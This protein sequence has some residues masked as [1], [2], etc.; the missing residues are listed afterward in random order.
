MRPRVVR[1]PPGGAG[2]SIAHALAL[3]LAAVLLSGCAGTPQTWA[4]TQSPPALPERFELRQVP[5]FPQQA[6]QC[7]P[8][9]LATLLVHEGVE[10]SPEALTPRLFIPA[11]EGT[12]QLELLAAA[13]GHDRLAV[14]LEPELGAVL[15]AVA[16]GHPVL[17]LQNLGLPIAP[18]WHYAVVVGYDLA[19]GELVLR[20]GAERRWITPLGTF[21]RTWA[22]GEHWA[23]VTVAPGEVPAG[24]TLLD[25]LAAARDLEAGGKQA[26]ARAS[27]AAAAR[28][29]PGR[30]LPELALANLDYAQGDL[31]AAE[32]ALRRAVRAEPESV[33][34]WNN[35]AH[36]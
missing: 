5:F 32:A 22:R 28:A 12:L 21:E 30:A 9:A 10:T 29:W 2:S 26:A 14:A 15:D 20:S 8:A 17:V 35:L 34:A 1:R 24:V 7:G 19:A 13:R 16:A 31:E 18:R 27:Y 3:A 25:Y 23:I 4:L 6:L 11:R 36:V 33:A